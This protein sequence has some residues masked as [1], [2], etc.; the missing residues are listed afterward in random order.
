MCSSWFA[1]RLRR[2]HRYHQHG[3][4]PSRREKFILAFAAIRQITNKIQGKKGSWNWKFAS[5]HNNKNEFWHTAKSIITP[6]ARTKKKENFKIFRGCSLLLLSLLL[7]LFIIIN[8]FCLMVLFYFFANFNN[9][10]H[11]KNQLLI[12]TTTRNWW[13]ILLKFCF[14]CKSKQYRGKSWLLAWNQAEK[15]QILWQIFEVLS[16]RIFKKYLN[17][18]TEIEFWIIM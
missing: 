16:A 18:K 1:A 7:L 3:R 17:I 12:K 6:P 5:G 14:V 4:L 8:V 10:Q 11:N 9:N 2:R 15:N 13:N